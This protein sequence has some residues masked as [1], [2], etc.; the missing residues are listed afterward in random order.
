MIKKKKVGLGFKKNRAIIFF[1]APA[2]IIYT[3]FAVVSILASAYYSLLDWDG[4]GKPIFLGIK[5]YITLFTSNKTPF[6]QSILNSFAFAGVSLFIQLPFAIF[7][8]IVIVNVKRGE[9][10]FRTIYFI[11]VLIMTAITSQLWLKMYDPNYGL[12][13]AILRMLGLEQWQR[14]W[15]VDE[16]TALMSVIV[17]G[18]WQ[19]MG[20]YMLILY[21][22]IK[23]ISKDI[24]EAASIDGA[25]KFQQAIHIIIPMIMPAVHICVTF[26]VVG[27]MKAF[28]LI[29]MITRGGPMNMTEVPTLT[30]FI[31]TFEKQQ[32]GL[33]SSMTITT[34]FFCLIY[35]LVINKIFKKSEEV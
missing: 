8:S 7:V 19:W 18:L 5:N 30:M 27:S 34:V 10:F 29:Y 24:F 15:T 25:S 6:R 17:P 11:P 33:G 23:S 16:S 14:N 35:A 12:F 26:M 2:F 20:Y 9:K 32:Y 1:L 4:I 13:N 3:C 21:T 28:D 22:G 31:T